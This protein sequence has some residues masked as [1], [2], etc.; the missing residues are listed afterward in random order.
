M[1][2]SER[3]R[4]EICGE[5]ISK[6]NLKAH[7]RRHENHPETFKQVYKVDH[8]GLECKFC[9]KSCKSLNSLTQHEM[10]CKENPDKLQHSIQGFNNQGR[11]AWNKGLDMST[12]DR[13][14]KNSES[15]R[16]F[17]TTHD[18]W[19]LGKS[20]TDEH[21]QKISDTCL[22]KSSEGTWHTSLAKDHHYSYRGNDLH[23]KWEL[24][25]AKYLDSQG[26]VWVRCKERFAYTYQDKEHYYTPDFYLPDEDV[27]VEVKGY[28]TGKDSAKWKQFPK[29]KKLRVLQYKE[30]KQL[31]LEIS[32]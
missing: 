26:V 31:G 13:V 23:C 3:I 21:R 12:D 11:P 20:L 16:H 9:K 28:R 15:I 8:E 22:R 18:G 27:Y 2:C 4:C 30:L 7:L 19:A 5:T 17:Y 14:K 24:E 32:N 1:A 6:N 29:N 10:R 25:Y